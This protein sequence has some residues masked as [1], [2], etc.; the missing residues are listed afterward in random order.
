M[1]DLQKLALTPQQVA[2][3]PLAFQKIYFKN[4]SADEAH[5]NMRR[6][7]ATGARIMVSRAYEKPVSKL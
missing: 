6:V 4:L 2:A 7:E 3:L 1:K 5:P